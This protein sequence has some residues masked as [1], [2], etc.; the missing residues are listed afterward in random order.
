MIHGLDTSVVMRLLTGDPPEQAEV[1]AAFLTRARAA[2]DRLLVADIVIAEAYFALHT[3]YKVPK[4]EALL[5]LRE[6][7]ESGEVEAGAAHEVLRTPNLA[8]AK[9]GFV[10]RLIHAAYGNDQARL[11]SFEKSAGSLT[12][13]RLLV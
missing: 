3:K 6:F 13:A 9:P 12:G 8:S 11:V 10:D 4:A 7:V 2:G 5:R 1:A